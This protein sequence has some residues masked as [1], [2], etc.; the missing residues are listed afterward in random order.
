MEAKMPP[1]RMREIYLFVFLA[2]N[3]ILV[4]GTYG[5][6]GF[7]GKAV[8]GFFFGIFGGTF[9]VLPCH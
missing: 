9:Y 8:S 6:C 3:L 4:L 1:E 5:V 7:V 2:F